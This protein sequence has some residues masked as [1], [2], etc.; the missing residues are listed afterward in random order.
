MNHKIFSILAY[1]YF[2][3]MNKTRHTHSTKDQS[4]EIERAN[5][6]VIL[7]RVYTNLQ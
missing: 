3:T 6:A 2:L 7:L 1:F 4:H 5:I